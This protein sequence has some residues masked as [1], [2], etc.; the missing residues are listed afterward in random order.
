VEPELVVAERSCLCF[1][2]SQLGLSH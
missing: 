2:W 1:L